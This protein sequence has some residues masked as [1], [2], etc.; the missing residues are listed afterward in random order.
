MVFDVE[1]K[2]AYKCHDC[3]ELHFVLVEPFNINNKNGQFF[4]CYLGGKGLGI[5]KAYKDYVI[6]MECPNCHEDIDHRVSAKNFWKDETYT[7]ICPECGEYAFSL[8]EASTSIGKALEEYKNATKKQMIPRA[9]EHL[10]DLA[11]SKQ[12]T[13]E[14]GCNDISIKPFNKGMKAICPRCGLAK[15]ILIRNYE[16]AEKITGIESYELKDVRK[17]KVLVLDDVLQEYK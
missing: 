3:G 13:C 10:K 15:K 1:K 2:I 17:N 9:G 12:M 7:A 6:M 4:P 8:L 5:V 14:C 16:D 11:I